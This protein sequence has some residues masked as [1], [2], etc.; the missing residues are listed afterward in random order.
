M[1]VVRRDVEQTEVVLVRLHVGRVVNLEAHLG[2]DRVVFAEVLRGDVQAAVARR[3]A[4]QGH[5]DRAARQLG[6]QRVALKRLLPLAKRGFERALDLVGLLS[7]SRAFFP[8]QGADD[9]QSGGQRAA[10]PA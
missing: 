1:R 2:K 7:V 9:V 4:R 10:L 8:G 5:V 6:L 3:P